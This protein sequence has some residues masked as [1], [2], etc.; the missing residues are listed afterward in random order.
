MKSLLGTHLAYDRV[1]VCVIVI[2][3]H[4]TTS[5]QI[6][7]AMMTS[8]KVQKLFLMIMIFAQRRMW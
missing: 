5:V 8:I 2:D 6:K 1:F 4:C 7:L 3:V